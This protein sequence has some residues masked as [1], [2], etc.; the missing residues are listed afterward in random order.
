MSPHSSPVKKLYLG[1]CLD[2]EIAG[3]PQ[4]SLPAVYEGI[5][6][7]ICD[8]TSWQQATHLLDSF[9]PGFIPAKIKRVILTR[10][11]IFKSIIVITKLK[12]S[13][14][15]VYGVALFNISK[16]YTFQL[17]CTYILWWGQYVN[18]CLFV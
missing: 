4:Y 3:E 7:R 8:V 6:C 1:D 9:H 11:N 2:L 16:H 13:F 15:F 17:E 5:F 18:Q 14:H 10:T 12:C